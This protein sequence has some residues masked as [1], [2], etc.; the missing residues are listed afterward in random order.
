MVIDSSIWS[1]FSELQEFPDDEDGNFYQEV[2]TIHDITH[3]NITTPMNDHDIIP[4]HL[5]PYHEMNLPSPKKRRF[6][7]RDKQLSSLKRQGS[8]SSS[9]TFNFVN[10]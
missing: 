6:L 2:R 5:A 7:S 10:Q 1:D 4:T 8:S 3:P 9:I